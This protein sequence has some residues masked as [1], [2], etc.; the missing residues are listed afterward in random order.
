MPLGLDQKR[1]QANYELM[2]CAQQDEEAI[3]VL[4]D[5]EQ[6]IYESTAVRLWREN[7]VDAMPLGD[8]ERAPRDFICD[9]ECKVSNIAWFS[10]ADGCLFESDIAEDWHS[11]CIGVVELLTHDIY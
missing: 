10:E 11:V 7:T 8:W 4:A 1:D 3:P 5:E 2:C 6:V 9:L